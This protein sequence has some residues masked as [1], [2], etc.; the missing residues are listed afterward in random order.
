MAK[1]ETT[2]SRD[3]PVIYI[4]GKANK[5]DRTFGTKLT[6]VPGQTHH[7]VASIA[8]NFLNCAGVYTT[9]GTPELAE[10]IERDPLN[11]AKH[12]LV[13]LS[14]E[15]T[16]AAKAEA[17]KKAAEIEAA[18]K[19]KAEAE[20]QEG[21]VIP[22]NPLDEGEGDNDLLLGDAAREI[23]LLANKDE[24]QKWANENELDVKLVGS[25]ADMEAQALTAYEKSLN[26]LDEEG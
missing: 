7:L 19:A 22:A 12:G 3:L 20:K 26:S 18:A 15:E 8:Q 10:F 4:G 21:M 14:D 5:F 25:R 11:A 13:E 24:V 9:T 2:A 17:D 6:F 16:I 1:I 23:G